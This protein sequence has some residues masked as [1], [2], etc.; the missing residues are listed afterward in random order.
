MEL[1]VNGEKIN[2]LSNGYSTNITGT[3][4]EITYDA[5]PTDSNPLEVTLHLPND[6]VLKIYRD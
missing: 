1:I 5:I 3:T 2:L 6:Q 4:F